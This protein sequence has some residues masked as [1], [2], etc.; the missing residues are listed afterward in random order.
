[1]NMGLPTVSGAG[2]FDSHQKF[3]HLTLTPWR[4]VEEYE[5][6][7]FLN[8]KGNAFINQE[9]YA[10][11]HGAILLAKPGDR[12]RSRLPF[13]CYFVHFSA[14]SAAMSMFLKDFPAFVSGDYYEALLPDAKEVA[15]A[16]LSDEKHD[17]IIIAQKLLKLLL[18]THAVIHSESQSPKNTALENQIVA[19]AMRF[20]EENY[21]T[22][23]SIP[24]IAKHC[25]ISI[26]QLYRH[27]STTN[28]EPPKNYLTK[29][30]IR[31]AKRMLLSTDLSIGD[32]A[33]QCGYA[34]H[35]HFCY[36]FK[37]KEGM[38]PAEYRNTA[39]YYL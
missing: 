10:I 38:S 17:D 37:E 39:G 3:P 18:H 26:A 35:A 31:S 8:D 16:F 32:I 13:S 15:H 5:F 4:V 29:I 12:R 24:D 11:K 9:E 6:E 34:S 33:M 14:C 7:L 30:R 1:M 20:M 25:N 36:A 2:F 27:F 28:H 22:A 23:I 19:K 21:D